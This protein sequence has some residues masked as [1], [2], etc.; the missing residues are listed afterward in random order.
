MPIEPRPLP[1]EPAAFAPH[2]PAEVVE[3]HRQA[4]QA[5]FD[6]LRALLGDAE[7][8]P[9][10]EV[11]A[12]EARGALAAH[13]A[14]AWAEDFHWAALCR[15]DPVD[16][17]GPGG[18][19]AAAIQ[20]AFGEPQRLRERFA[21][22]AGRLG[23]PGWL[24]LVLRRDERLAI[25]ATSRSATPLTGGDAPLLGCCLWP[26]AMPEEGDGALQRYLDGFWALVDWRVVD[27]RL[28]Q[29]RAALRPARGSATT[30]PAGR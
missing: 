25:V 5:T 18:A 2:L 13:A 8:V 9:A 15:P 16:P 1:C 17:G 3:R 7:D 14:Q 24:W 12:V 11:L 22:L 6:A 30:T 21:E 26:H 23:G 4:H 27:A 10:P 28:E 20:Q 19:L 29:A